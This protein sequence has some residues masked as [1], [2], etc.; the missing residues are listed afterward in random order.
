MAVEELFARMSLELHVIDLREWHGDD[1]VALHAR[2]WAK[3]QVPGG[4]GDVHVA[5]LKAVREVDAGATLHKQYLVVSY[6][7]VLV[8]GEQA[9]QDVTLEDDGGEGGSNKS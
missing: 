7:I 5:L 3:V 4:D 9:A 1:D 2:H 8:G 6:V